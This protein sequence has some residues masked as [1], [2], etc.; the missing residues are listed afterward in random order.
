MREPLQQDRPA[1]HGRHERRLDRLVVAGQVQ[2]GATR[3]AR[4]GPSPG[5]LISTARPLGFDGDRVALGIRRP[6]CRCPYSSTGAVEAPSSRRLAA[7]RT[8]TR[9]GRRTPPPGWT[10]RSLRR[11]R[12]VRPRAAG[13]GGSWSPAGARRWSTPKMAASNAHLKPDRCWPIRWSTE[14]PPGPRAAMTADTA[15]DHADVLPPVL[16]H[17][18]ALALVVGAGRRGHQSDGRGRRQRVGGAEGD[19]GA[20]ADLGG[21]GQAGVHVGRLQAEGVEPAGR[22]LE[23]AFAEHLVVAVGHQHGP[24]G[25]AQHEGRDICRRLDGWVWTVF[26]TGAKLASSRPCHLQASSP[27]FRPRCPCGPVWRLES[28]APWPGCPAASGAAGGRSSAVGPSWPSIPNAL[29]RLA[30]GRD[31]ALVSGT[32]GKTTTTSLLRRGLGNRR[33]GGHQRPRRQPAPRAGRR[34]GR[35]VRPAR[36]RPSRWTRPGWVGWST[37]PRP[38]WWRCST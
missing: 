28:V 38:G 4:R 27:R 35:P 15:A 2:L 7:A 18:E 16:E 20:G 22:A 19:H 25:Q 37:P 6:R 11:A 17:E 8:A 14:I 1:A 33:A 36:P 9:S 5:W 23:P 13:P 30:A 12:P 31:V 21:R 29:R 32:N 34:P 10:R 3:L 24:D 26:C